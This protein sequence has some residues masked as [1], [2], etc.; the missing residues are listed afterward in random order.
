MSLVSPPTYEAVSRH[1]PRAQLSTG[2]LLWLILDGRSVYSAG[3]PLPRYELSV[4]PREATS[5]FLGIKKLRYRLSRS[6]GQG[7][8]R[9]RLDDMYTCRDTSF[10][11]HTRRHVIINGRTRDSRTYSYARLRPGITGWS[12]CSIAGYFKAVR[13][14]R[15]KQTIWNDD[16]G[17]TIATEEE[18]LLME[19]G[20]LRSTPSLRLLHV[21]S[22]RDLDLIVTCWTAR[23]WKEARRGRMP[24]T[25]G[26]ANLFLPAWFVDTDLG[27]AT[28]PNRKPGIASHMF[29]PCPP[30]SS[31]PER[32][33]DHGFNCEALFSCRSLSGANPG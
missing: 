3:S 32:G 13:G 5:P 25:R 29:T 18:A 22:D 26:E 28:A 19:S 10:R 24:W 20:E 33:Y 27:P 1:G 4:S 30:Y 15:S 17:R 6:N 14:R 11:L 8:L 21:L 16:A 31:F 9:I 2:E 23:L 7:K 12:S